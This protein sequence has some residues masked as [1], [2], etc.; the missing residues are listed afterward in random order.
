MK[1]AMRI[2]LT[3]A[4]LILMTGLLALN[5]TH[6]ESSARQKLDN[7]LGKTPEPLPLA[8]EAQALPDWFDKPN[9]FGFSLPKTGVRVQETAEAYILR[10]PVATPGD[11]DQVQVNVS[12]GRIE[13]SGQTGSQHGNMRSSSSF[14]QSFTTSQPVLPQKMSKKVEKNG[15]QNELVITIPKSGQANKMEPQATSPAPP[16]LSPSRERQLQEEL[17]RDNPFDDQPHQVI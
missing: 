2:M 4:A 15:E 10:V 7:L 14:F 13:V 16:D 17:E 12:P 5:W 11:A 9:L 6:H 1:N 8:E 3:L